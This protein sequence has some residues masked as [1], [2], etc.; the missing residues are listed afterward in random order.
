MESKFIDFLKEPPLSVKHDSSYDIYDMDSG[1]TCRV[2]WEFSNNRKV[3][4]VLATC[5][6]SDEFQLTGVIIRSKV[7]YNIF[8]SDHHINLESLNEDEKQTIF[9]LAM[10]HVTGKKKVTLDDLV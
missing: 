3:I 8:N 6:Y 7:F 10:E 2:M 5:F 4:V 1:Q 9:N